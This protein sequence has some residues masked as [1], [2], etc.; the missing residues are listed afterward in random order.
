MLHIIVSNIAISKSCFTVHTWKDVITKMTKTL[1][2]ENNSQ[3][4]EIDI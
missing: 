4:D 1:K 2:S 3:E